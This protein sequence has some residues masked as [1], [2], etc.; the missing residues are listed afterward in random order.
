MPHLVL[1]LPDEIQDKIYRYLL[2]LNYNEVI[3]EYRY[4]DQRINM[5]Y[6]II[7]QKTHA[8]LKFMNQDLEE[9]RSLCVHRVS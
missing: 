3:N 4:S 8:Y 1:S 9:L 6:S 2:Y 7:N 5:L